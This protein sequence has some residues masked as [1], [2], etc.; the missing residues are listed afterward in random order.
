MDWLTDSTSKGLTSI[1]SIPILQPKE[2]TMEGGSVDYCNVY[3]FV[4]KVELEESQDD[5]SIA[6]D[7]TP[8]CAICCGSRRSPGSSQSRPG[9]IENVPIENLTKYER[10]L[11]LISNLNCIEGQ[12]RWWSRPV[13][14]WG[15]GDGRLSM[16]T[17]T[18]ATHVP[19]EISKRNS[20]ADCYT[21]RI[22]FL[23]EGSG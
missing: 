15:G 13:N 11:S 6:D 18:T 2:N 22:Q 5:S 7:R 4:N 12:W 21:F 3:I 14:I 23:F 1:A 9:Q 8:R 19:I 20:A 10:W 17:T 16:T